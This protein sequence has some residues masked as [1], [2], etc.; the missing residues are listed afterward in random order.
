MNVYQAR[1]AAVALLLALIVFASPV[2]PA[3][4]ESA[5]PAPEG[6][7]IVTK[8]GE[9]VAACFTGAEISPQLRKAL[10]GLADRAYAMFEKRDWDGLWELSQADKAKGVSKEAFV[11]GLTAAAERLG[12]RIDGEADEIFVFRFSQAFSAVALCG[13]AAT[14]DPRHVAVQVASKGEPLALILRRSRQP[15]FE[16]TITFVFRGADNKSWRFAGVVGSDVSFMGRGPQD[17]AKAAQIYRAGGDH[18]AELLALEIAHAFSKGAP[19][20]ERSRSYEMSRRIKGLITDGE[21]FDTVR[22]LKVDGA[23]YVLR[24]VTV[25]T[26]RTGIRPRLVYLSRHGSKDPRGAEEARAVAAQIARSHPLA[27]ENFSDVVLEALVTAQE[28]GGT[29]AAKRYLE[30]LAR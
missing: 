2:E 23:D 27:A 25:E 18:L 24:E 10:G 22:K 21:R 19:F 9:A 3:G 28:S 20:I 7:G 17:Y 6:V 1:A 8:S 12:R 14:D 30:S 16:R 5:A 26:T 11:S 13:A 15:P 29:V 4:A